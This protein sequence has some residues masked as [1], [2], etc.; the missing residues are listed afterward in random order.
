MLDMN[1]QNDLALLLCPGY[2]HGAVFQA[3]TL[4]VLRACAC[5]VSTLV[6]DFGPCWVLDGDDCIFTS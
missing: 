6:L 5:L 2:D 1:T 4:F 3:H